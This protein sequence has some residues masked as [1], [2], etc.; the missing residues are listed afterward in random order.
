M[1]TGIE[2]SKDGGMATLVDAAPKLIMWAV[3]MAL[4]LGFMKI[5]WFAIPKLLA[6]RPRQRFSDLAD[7]LVAL[8][9]PGRGW[10]QDR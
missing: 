4:T 5:G 8:R 3:L 6:L 1:V 2:E 10:L 7:T 9:A